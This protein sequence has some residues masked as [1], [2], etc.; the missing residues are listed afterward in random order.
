MRYHVQWGHYLRCVLRNDE[1]NF[2]FTNV[3]QYSY[4]ECNVN[5]DLASA[6]IYQEESP[7]Y[8]S[9][10]LISELGCQ[11]IIKNNTL[12]NTTYSNKQVYLFSSRWLINYK[13]VR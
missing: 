10:K 9:G 3:Q 1:I 2:V 7:V 8:Y 12:G 11:F 13:T 4:K 6:N 5:S